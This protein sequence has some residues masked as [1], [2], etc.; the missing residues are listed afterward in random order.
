MGEVHGFGGGDPMLDVLDGDASGYGLGRLNLGQRQRGCVLALDLEPHARVRR[1]LPRWCMGEQV[2]AS[3]DPG[4]VLGVADLD[5]A[6]GEQHRELRQYLDS[7]SSWTP[8][9]GTVPACHDDPP[10]HRSVSAGP[11]CAGPA[12]LDTERC[13]RAAAQ[14]PTRGSPDHLAVNE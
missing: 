11:P 1:H 4:A 3:V 14:G 2:E 7:K 9:T 8:I 13:A 10:L 6:T 5:A 12:P